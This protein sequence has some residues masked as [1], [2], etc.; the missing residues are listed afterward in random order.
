MTQSLTIESSG[1]DLRKTI[2]FTRGGVLITKRWE[3]YRIQWCLGIQNL[4]ENRSTDR[5]PYPI[6]LDFS[7]NRL[8]SLY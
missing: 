1:I 6:L 2:E 3:D 8:Y 7:E 4:V 5:K